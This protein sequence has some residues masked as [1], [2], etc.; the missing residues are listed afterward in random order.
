MIIQG[1]QLTWNLGD[2]DVGLLRGLLAL[3]L[4]LLLVLRDVSKNVVVLLLIEIFFM[5]NDRLLLFTTFIS[6]REVR[7]VGILWYILWLLLRGL[8]TLVI[9]YVVNSHF[10]AILIGLYILHGLLLLVH[11][12]VLL[13]LAWL[14]VWGLNVVLRDDI[15]RS[16]LIPVLVACDG[17]FDLL[18]NLFFLLI[19][20]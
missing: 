4:G 11:G 15:V 19:L 17:L 12:L 7:L 3:W 14:M 16:H 2:F 9:D 6:Q 5:G 1:G 13:H 18:V 8:V 10:I 20:A